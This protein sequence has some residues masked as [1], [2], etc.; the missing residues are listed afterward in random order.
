[1]QGPEMPVLQPRHGGVS[2]TDRDNV[3]AIEFFEKKH[4]GLLAAD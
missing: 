1:M 3:T 2:Q 4:I